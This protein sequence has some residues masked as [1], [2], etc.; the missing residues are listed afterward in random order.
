[1]DELNLEK[2]L[3]IVNEEKLKRGLKTYIPLYPMLRVIDDKLYVAVLLTDETDDVYSLN[4]SVKAKY[5]ALIDIKTNKLLEFNETSKKDFVITPFK[6]KN[7]FEKQQELSKYT[8]RKTLEYKNYLMTD[9]KNEQLP[10]QKK[11]ATILGNDIY[12]EGEKVNLN[13]YLFSK[14]E[15]DITKQIDSLVNLLVISKYGSITFYYDKLFT[16]IID[17][18]QKNGTINHDELKLCVEMMDYYYDGI[19]GLA[20]LFN[21]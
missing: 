6:E 18:Y 13:D 7:T 8:V 3:N 20:N 14:L 12:I 5:W 21:I 10:F 11:L 2:Y 9:I 15:E 16:T 17:N 4:A 1:M 19:I